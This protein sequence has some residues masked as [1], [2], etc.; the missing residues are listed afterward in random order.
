MPEQLY[1]HVKNLQY[2]LD[3]KVDGP[4]SPYN[5]VKERNLLPL[6]ETEPTFLC[7]PACHLITTL[8]KQCQQQLKNWLLFQ[9][10]GSHSS[11]SEDLKQLVICLVFFVRQYLNVQT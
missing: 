5:V 3:R 4:Q 1:P 10:R 6:K 9:I 2:P 7:H 11:V 8:N